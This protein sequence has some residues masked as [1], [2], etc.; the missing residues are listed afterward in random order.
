MVREG[1]D[2]LR[3]EQVREPQVAEER[4]PFIV[5]HGPHEQRRKGVALL[6]YE[7]AALDPGAVEPLLGGD[8]DLCRAAVVLPQ[9]D[10]DPFGRFAAGMQLPWINGFECVG[11]E[12]PAWMPR[13]RPL[14]QGG[15]QPAGGLGDS[16]GRFARHVDRLD[17]TVHVGLHEHQ[18]F[19]GVQV[20]R[21]V[22]QAFRRQKLTAVAMP[23]RR[24]DRDHRRRI[25]VETDV[26]GNQIQARGLR[27]VAGGV[28]LDA[29]AGLRKG[30]DRLPRG[31][32]RDG[33]IEILG[34]RRVGPRHER[35]P[36][37]A[38]GRVEP[39]PHAAHGG[40]R[41]GCDTAGIEDRGRLRFG[42]RRTGPPLRNAHRAVAARLEPWP[43]GAVGRHEP[44]QRPHAG[45]PR[46]GECVEPNAAPAAGILGRRDDGRLE[47]QEMTPRRERADRQVAGHGVGDRFRFPDAAIVDP[48]AN[49]PRARDGRGRG[50]P[51]ELDADVIADCPQGD[52]PGRPGP[53]LKPAHDGKAAGRLPI[54]VD[55]GDSLRLLRLP[56][57]G[58]SLGVRLD[59]LRRERMQRRR[60]KRRRVGLDLRDPGSADCVEHP[61]LDRRHVAHRRHVQHLGHRRPEFGRAMM[62]PES[63]VAFHAAHH[64]AFGIEQRDGVGGGARE[65]HAEPVDRGGSPHGHDDRGRQPCRPPRRVVLAVGHD[66]ER[67]PASRDEGRPAG[68]QIAC[69]IESGRC[70]RVIPNDEL[71]RLRVGRRRRGPQRPL[72]GARMHHVGPRQGRL[73]DS[74]SA[75]QKR[76]EPSGLRRGRHGRP[77]ARGL[78]KRID[79][80]RVGDVPG[81]HAVF[82]Q[83]LDRE[84]DQPE[85][86]HRR[87]H[88]LEGLARHRILA[89]LPR[90]PHQQS[91]MGDGLLDVVG[92]G[93]EV[94]ERQTQGGRTARHVAENRGGRRLLRH[95]G[96]RMGIQ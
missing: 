9:P 74:V 40:R 2:P 1:D 85:L 33:G 19:G 51:P 14:R 67:R 5:A 80:R 65:A 89:A 18:A 22:P 63:P 55:H 10:L 79:R 41:R 26:V 48:P 64:V 43:R 78:A 87:S 35:R 56:G 76:Q 93:R 92:V 36:G 58:D 83:M 75:F 12:D 46:D 73:H 4:H 20:G 45:P 39:Q 25:A 32:R 11:R 77:L 44:N 94:V 6:R 47:L 15:R 53:R 96:R 54:G 59:V 8:A 68:E 13:G 88:C 30:D 21:I 91:G 7:F 29:R 50:I 69:R 72:V 27:Q 90:I 34:E 17:P 62:L 86:L 38:R 66:V 70:H 23:Q 95:P 31:D 24:A 82:R 81:L 16:L 42:R 60:W 49:A 52:R 28:M 84:I 3:Q 37:L 71:H 61:H 57:H